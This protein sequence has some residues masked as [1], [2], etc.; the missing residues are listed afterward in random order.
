[1]LVSVGELLGWE[2]LLGWQAL[3]RVLVVAS[4]WIHITDTHI[5]SHTHHSD[6]STRCI[7]A[8]RER[9]ET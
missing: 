4:G 8:V 2:R 9:L 7:V 5:N 6:N 3:F 1:M